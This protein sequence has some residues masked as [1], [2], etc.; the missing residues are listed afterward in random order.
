MFNWDMIPSLVEILKKV[1]DHE[2]TPMLLC[3]MTIYQPCEKM[4]P[5][6]EIT[7]LRWKTKCTI[8]LNVPRN[9]STLYALKPNSQS[10][11]SI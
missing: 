4:Q 2:P 1:H 11:H 3:Q 6:N 7:K 10:K 8:S 5:I 9:I